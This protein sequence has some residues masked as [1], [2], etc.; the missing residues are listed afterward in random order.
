L[1][2][3]TF[4]PLRYV[5]DATENGIHKTAK[6]TFEARD[7]TI[8]AEFR[9][10]NELGSKQFHFAHDGLDVVGAAFLLRQLPLREHLPLCFDVYGIRTLWRAV[11]RVEGKETVSTPLGEFRAWHLSGVAT[12]VDQPRQRREIHLWLTDDERRLPLTA[13]GVIDLGAVRATLTAVTRPGQSADLTKKPKI[14]W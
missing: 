7:R 10:G 6:V 9:V 13:M 4:H 5:E 8:R 11:G 1:N 2:P 14:K 12:R 3:K